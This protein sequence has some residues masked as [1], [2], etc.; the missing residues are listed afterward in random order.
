MN[1]VLKFGLKILNRSGKNVRKR[2]GG[3]FLLTLYIQY[4]MPG[5]YRYKHFVSIIKLSIVF[6]LTVA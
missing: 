2:Q 4:A 5:L 6:I 1:F 3:F